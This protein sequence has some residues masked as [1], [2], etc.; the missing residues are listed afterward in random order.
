MNKELE[1]LDSQLDKLV[2]EYHKARQDG[3]ND[4]ADSIF[5]KIERLRI[6]RTSLAKRLRNKN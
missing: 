2:T 4:S 1:R 5:A 6:Q 3:N